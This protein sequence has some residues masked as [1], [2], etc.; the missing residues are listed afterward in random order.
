MVFFYSLRGTQPQA[1]NRSYLRE[2]DTGRERLRPDDKMKHPYLGLHA[3]S[4]DRRK[5][6]QKIAAGSGPTW[7]LLSDV[8]LVFVVPTWV[9]LLKV[10][11]LSLKIWS[12]ISSLI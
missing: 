4:K 12:P 6:S 7:V 9:R 3:A 8:N 2:K 1:P 10:N 11:T 5:H